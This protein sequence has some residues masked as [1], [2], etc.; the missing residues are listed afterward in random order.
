MGFKTIAKFIKIE[1]PG[2]LP[3]VFG[4]LKIAGAL[5]VRVGFRPILLAGAVLYLAGL[6]MLAAAQGFLGVLAGAGLL[7][8]VAL[9]CTASAMAQATSSRV[10]PTAAGNAASSR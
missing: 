6:L 3:L 5:V 8:G 1:F 2:A 9:A 10:V 7:I 4:G